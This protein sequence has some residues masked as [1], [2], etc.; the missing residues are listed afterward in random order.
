[1]TRPPNVEERLAAALGRRPTVAEIAAEVRR[2]GALQ[3]RL[4]ILGRGG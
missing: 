3:A 1:M 4:G 2:V